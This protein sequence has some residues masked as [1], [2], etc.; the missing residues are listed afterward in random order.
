MSIQAN[1]WK[2]I[3]A[4]FYIFSK[5]IQK[6]RHIATLVS[7]LTTLALTLFLDGFIKIPGNPLPPL[8]QFLHPITGIWN[9]MVPAY[10]KDEAISLPGVSGKAKLIYDDR[11]VP[12]IFAPTLE[13]AIF[14]QGWVEAENRLFQMDFMTRAASGRLSEVMGP[15]TLNFDKEKNRSQIE[16]T[17]DN[18]IAAW[19]KHPE[20][21]KLLQKYIDGVNA[22]IE[23]LKPEDYPIEYKLLDFKPEKWTAKKSALV[24]SSM[25]DVLCGRSDDLESTN[26]LAVLGRDLFDAIYP[27]QEDGGFPVIPYEKK[28]N[29]TNPIAKEKADSIVKGPFY[30]YYYENRIKGIGSNNWAVSPSKSK[31]G[32]PILCNDPHLSL[33]LPSIWIEEH[34]VTPAF[35]AYGV[36]FPGIPGI[37]IGFNDHIAWGETNVGQDVEDLFQIEWMDKAKMRYKSGTGSALATTVI[38]RIKVKGMDDVLDTIKYTDKGVVRFES[39]DGKTDIAVRWLPSDP[40]NEAELMT[41]LDIMQAKN[42]DEFKQALNH[43][44]TPAQ[45]FIFASKTGDIALFVNGLF[46]MRQKE[47]GRFVEPAANQEGDWKEYIPREQ[48][49]SIENPK[50]GYIASANQRSAGSDYPFYYTGKFEHARNVVINQLLKDTA[51]WDMEG[52]QKMQANSFNHFASKALPEILKILSPTYTTHP[53]YQSWSKWDYQYK[54]ASTQATSYEAMYAALYELTFDE[55]LSYK[56]TMDIL[57]PEDWRMIDLLTRDSLS[58]VFDKISTKNKK[59]SRRDLVVE[60]FEKTISPEQLAKNSIPWGKHKELNI[61][62]YT[63]LPAFS[64][65]GLSVDGTPDAI[66][67]VGKAYGP[68]WRM[69]I[70]MAGGENTKAMGVYPGGQSG[71]PLSPFYKNMVTTWAENK[72]NDLNHVTDVKKIKSLKTIN[73]N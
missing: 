11:W 36:S 1:I 39:A 3:N 16:S 71:N 42:K 20:A 59:E 5:K 53:L 55:I 68:S 31:T 54:A 45:N 48:N 28:Y 13:D 72:Y 63:R 18:A 33:S 73:I 51:K 62:H 47:D 21:M 32:H 70:D 35:N 64:V 8:G 66:N 7:L 19:S 40:K 50:S 23:Q 58:V 30:Q 37:M 29:F 15:L 2:L 67:A 60:A 69:I 6:L 61:P 65:N 17:A 43:F 38:K 25:A 9:N 44:N 41:F 46:P 49:P 26:S 22:Y 27:E 4:K 52:M 57:Y 10:Y 34:I 24:Y 56:D 14:L 12:H